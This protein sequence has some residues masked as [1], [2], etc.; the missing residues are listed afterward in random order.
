MDTLLSRFGALLLAFLAATPSIAED[1]PRWRGPTA[2]GVWTETGVLERFSS[3]QVP[4]RWRAEVGPGYTSPTVA[5]GRV[6]LM[7]RDVQGARQAERVLCFDAETG[8]S[9]WTHE[10][11]CPY[12]K[13]GYQAGPRACVTID[14][15]RAFALGAMGN[16]HCLDAATGK[17]QWSH[18]CNQEYRIDMPIWGIAASP[19][20]DGDLVIVVVGGQD[21]CVVAFDKH[22]GREVWRA[23]SDRAQ[24]STPVLI[25]QA[26]VSVLVCWTGD[27]VSGLSP[28]SGKVLWRHEF[29]PNKM[30]IGVASP[31]V[32]GDRL[33]LTS[34]YDGSLML[35]LKQDQPAVEVLWKRTGVSERQTD[36]LHS[37]ISTPVFLGDYVYG[38]DSYGEMR[39]L[40]AENGDRV[41]ENLTATP[42]SRWSTI[43]FVQNGDKS[44][45]FNERGELLI[46]Q[47]MPQ[48]FR[49][50]SRAKLL[51]PTLE[52]LNQRGGVCW[53]HPAYANRHVFAR[54]D[55]ELVCASLLTAD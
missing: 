3:P 32:Q 48:G 11:D 15:D 42:K 20:V 28:K 29:P 18:D 1:W 2:D 38:V 26:G 12:S 34:F 30:P 17:V 43:H 45:L 25:Q 52:Q 40:R 53:S 35:R 21:A 5:A 37:I 23:L 47:L 22:D 6:F 8:R 39:C 46:G 27:S 54:N 16:L 14:G 9:V 33:F 24:Y 4:I 41:W 50:I 51:E 10:Y 7:D 36:A 44:W 49:E 13:I 19:V 55:S 31:V